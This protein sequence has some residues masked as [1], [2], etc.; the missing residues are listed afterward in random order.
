MTRREIAALCCRVVALVVLAWSLMYLVM[1]VQAFTATLGGPNSARYGSGSGPSLTSVEITYF[2]S[3]GCVLLLFSMALA[4]RAQWFTGWMAT[5]DPT[6]VTGP[7]L[8][9]EALMPVACAGVGLFAITRALPTF[10]RFVAYLLVG[11]TTFDEMLTA[12][13]KAS[14]LSEGL[15][16]AWGLWLLAGN[17]GLVRLLVWARSAGSDPSSTTPVEPPKQTS[18]DA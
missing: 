4:W 5:D 8:S 13:W 16:L 2:G 11:E 10:S 3:L 6:P 7:E 9:A 15:L 14:L 18:P 12:D 17:R 1:A